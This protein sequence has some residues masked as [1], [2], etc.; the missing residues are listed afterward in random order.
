MVTYYV[1]CRVS[2][3]VMCAAVVVMCDVGIVG[4]VVDLSDD[5]MITAVVVYVYLR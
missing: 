1:V 2:V 5:C 4:V 3:F